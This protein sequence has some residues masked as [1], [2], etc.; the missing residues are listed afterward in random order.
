[1]DMSWHER[2]IE[3]KS[4]PKATPQQILQRY[5]EQRLKSDQEKLTNGTTIHS[6][7]V[8]LGVR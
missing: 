5:R 2:S 7:V 4:Q 8:Q 3:T 6:R 1:M